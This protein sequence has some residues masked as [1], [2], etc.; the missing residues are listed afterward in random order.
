[1]ETKQANPQGKGLASISGFLLALND[2]AIVPAKN[3]QQISDELFTSMFILNTKFSFKPVINTPYWLYQ[4]NDLFRLSLIA[5]EEWPDQA[6]G[7]ARGCCQLHADMTWTLE[8]NAETL[9][10]ADF[11]AMISQKRRA[12]DDNITQA[13][14]VAD[15]LPRYQERLPFYQRAFASALGNS[16]KRS[17]LKAQISHLSH[18][19][20][21]KQIPDQ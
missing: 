5:P 4:S 7:Q 3:I 21:L 18:Q 11:M 10:D 16:L 2:Q 12:F 19:Q 8:L 9:A 6:F 13:N 15:I 1:M 20:A 14:H 17:M